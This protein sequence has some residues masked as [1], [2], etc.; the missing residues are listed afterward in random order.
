MTTQLRIASM[1]L[2]LAAGLLVAS[3]AEAQ[4]PWNARDQSWRQ[5]DRGRDQGWRQQ[6]YD[7]GYREGAAQGERDGRDRRAFAYD[8]YRPYQRADSGYDRSY[9]DRGLYQRAFREGFAAGYRTGYYRDNRS[10]ALPRYG[11][12]GGPFYGDRDR[13]G[14]QGIRSDDYA[15]HNGYV[16]GYEKGVEDAR[17]HRSYDVQR[18]RRYRNGDRNYERWYGPRE[19]YENVYRDGF[20][21][22]Y[23]QA[24]REGA[25]YG[26][27]PR[28]W[29]LGLGFGRVR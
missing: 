16:D 24:Y 22:G 10:Q 26:Y 15:F 21:V 14:G 11:S 8:R 25:R 6:A 4:D 27:D 12:Q 7:R 17:K 23:D 3:R 1:A 28:G 13:R 18:H 29:R 9:G 2:M 20:R 5:D 19:F